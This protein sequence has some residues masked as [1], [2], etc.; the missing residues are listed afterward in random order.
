MLVER[1]FHV[2]LMLSSA[3]AWCRRSL[4]VSVGDDAPYF[5]SILVA[6]PAQSSASLHLRC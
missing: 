4:Q 1:V 2:Q 3:T 6:Q 5:G